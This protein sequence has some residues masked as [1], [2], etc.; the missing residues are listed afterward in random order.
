MNDAKR[1]GSETRKRTRQLSVRF[2][3]TEHAELLRRADA[4]GLSVPAYLRL[5]AID[6][7]PARA[8]RKPSVN[9]QQVAQLLAQIGKLGSN[10]N[11][12][13]RHMNSGGRPSFASIDQAMRDVT[14]MRDQCMKALGRAP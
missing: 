2:N 9:A 5:Q 8:S 6:A 7:A 10:V 4:V 13:A 11:Q 12:I 14:D 3:E 1:S